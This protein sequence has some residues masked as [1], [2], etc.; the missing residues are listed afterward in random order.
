MRAA[1]TNCHGRKQ[2]QNDRV[3]GTAPE[4]NRR[5]LRDH[6]GALKCWDGRG[7][8]PL[9]HYRSLNFVDVEFRTPR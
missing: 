2:W 1:I 3:P 9:D 6:A 8:Q 4:T 5:R 7:E